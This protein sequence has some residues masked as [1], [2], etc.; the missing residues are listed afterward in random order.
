M[1]TEFDDK[2]KIFTNVI[3]KR[4][5]P[6]LIQINGQ[7]IQGKLHVPPTERI[8]DELNA[9]EQFLAITDATIYGEDGEVLYKSQFLTLNREFIIWLI[10]EEELQS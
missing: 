1:A 3:S 10:P 5:I 6:V 9:A 8:K 4:P 2:G 7:R